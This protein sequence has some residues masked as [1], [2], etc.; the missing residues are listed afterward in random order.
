MI[1][2]TPFHRIQEL[3]QLILDGHPGV[4]YRGIWPTDYVIFP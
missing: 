4:G 1:V 2:L 3:R